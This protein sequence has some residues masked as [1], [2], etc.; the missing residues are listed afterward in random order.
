MYDSIVIVVDHS[1]FKTMNA[2]EFHALGKG[3]HVQYDLKYIL[4]QQESSI[5]L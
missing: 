5:N 2:S 3:K 4:D 1:Q